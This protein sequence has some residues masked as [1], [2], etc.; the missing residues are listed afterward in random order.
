MIKAFLFLFLLI[1]SS[2]IFE[3]KG[4]PSNLIAQTLTVKKD[5]LERQILYNGRVWKNQ[6]SVTDGD[7][8]FLSPVFATGS[9]SIDNNIFNQVKIKYDL[10]YD[11]LLI[12]KNDGTIIQL[13][14]EMINTFSLF[15]DNVT[16]R[17]K[18]FENHSAGSLNGYCQLLYDGEIKIYVK[19][20]KELIPTTITNGLPKF[21]Q[22]NKIYIVKS[23]K[24]QRTDNRK[25]LLN[26]FIEP[27]ERI[28]IKKYLR[29]NQIKISRNDPESF[30]RVIE[31]YESRSK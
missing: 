19:Y 24:I 21:S 14:K 18:N 23:G 3:F 12:Q 31:Y 5:S 1:S 11:E 29:S 26:L 13:N 25:D 4:I 10:F 27:D 8:F 30:R 15:T 22:T 2:D 6:F 9:V 28:L 17:F 20:N 16:Y 7:Q